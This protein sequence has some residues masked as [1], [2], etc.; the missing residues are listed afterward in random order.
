MDFG[1]I[2]HDKERI[3]GE[4]A[5][6]QDEIQTW[7]YDEINLNSEKEILAE[8]HNIVGK[9][10]MFWRQRFR[11]VWLEEGDKNSRFFHL[12]TMKHTTANKICEIKKGNDIIREDNDI[13]EEA[14]SGKFLP[15]SIFFSCI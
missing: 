8:L 13:A 7:G 3:L 2:F 10:E 1:N 15:N 9:E 4:L 5:E 14:L 11:S 12:S 6:V